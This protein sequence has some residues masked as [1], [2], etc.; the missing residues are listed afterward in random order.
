M[1][2]PAISRAACPPE[3][4]EDIESL[5]VTHPTLGQVEVVIEHLDPDRRPGERPLFGVKDVRRNGESVFDD[6]PF[7]TIVNLGDLIVRA[8]DARDFDNDLS[9]AEG[10][11]A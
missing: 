11:A 7:D 9:F 2:A 8:I 6:L 5:E 10:Y 3:V 1:S 4:D